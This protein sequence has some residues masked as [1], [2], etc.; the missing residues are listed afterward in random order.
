MRKKPIKVN[1]EQNK[2][3]LRIIYGFLMIM[4]VL[5]LIGGT[6]IESNGF[7]TDLYKAFVF[8]FIGMSFVFAAALTFCFFFLY[9]IFVI[10][11]YNPQRIIKS[12]VIKFA[13]GGIF[14]LIITIF[15]LIFGVTEAK[16]SI[17]SMKDYKNGEWQVKDLVVTDV[18]RGSHAHKGSLRTKSVLIE[19]DKDEMT[20]YFED[21]LIYKGEKYRFTYLDATK[22]IIKV[23][24]MKGETNP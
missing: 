12:S 18:Y 1:K 3:R 6:F 5:L 10:I 2:K 4:I 19:T 7:M 17:Q 21:F 24:E 23:E 14:T 8:N 16:K 13:I 11:I 15:L 20:L 9:H 22:T